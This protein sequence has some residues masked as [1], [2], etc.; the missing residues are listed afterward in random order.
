[1]QLYYLHPQKIR[2]NINEK[3]NGTWKYPRMPLSEVNLLALQ[4]KSI[5]ALLLW[6]TAPVDQKTRS[7]FFPRNTLF[8]SVL[9]QGFGC[10]TSPSVNFPVVIFVLATQPDYMFA[11]WVLL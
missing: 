4:T 2:K 6:E 7:V 3:D 8:Q 11:L 9:L 1:M 5:L 10:K